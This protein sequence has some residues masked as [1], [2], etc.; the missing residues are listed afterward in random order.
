MSEQQKF[1]DEA[2]KTHNAHR[3]RHSAPPLK[4]SLVLC[5]SAQEWAEKLLTMDVLPNS[6][7]ASKG[8]VGENTFS[9][10]SSDKVD[11]SGAPPQPHAMPLPAA[12]LYD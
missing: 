7:L 3:A 6:P 12:N 2:L 4:L 8:E 5:K 10:R 1:V 9:R 11:I